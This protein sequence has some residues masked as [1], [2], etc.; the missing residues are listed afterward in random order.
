[1]NINKFICETYH[2]FSIQMLIYYNFIIICYNLMRWVGH[3]ACMGDERGA[4]KVFGG[5][6]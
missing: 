1:M 3:V 2:L 4:D 6:T 5:D